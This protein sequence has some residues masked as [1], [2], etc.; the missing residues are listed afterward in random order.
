MIEVLMEEDRWSEIG[1]E[2][3][4]ERA[5]GAALHH[6]GLAPDAWEVS[7]LAGDDARIAALNKAFRAKEAPTNVLS[8][9]SADRN[10]L[11]DPSEGPE[12]GDIALAYETCRAEAEASGL[13][14]ADHVAHLLVHGTLHLLGYD[15]EDDADAERMEQTE[16]AILATLG[17]PDPY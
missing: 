14:F 16:T 13:P 7:V 10:G 6:L 11:P 8:W 1:F 5:V 12:L 15:H 4:A 17:I 2:A 3:L 9:P